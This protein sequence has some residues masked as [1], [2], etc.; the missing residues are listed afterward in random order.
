MAHW[1]RFEG[2]FDERMAAGAC[3]RKEWLASCFD[4]I[5]I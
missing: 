1:K 3:R 4:F 2:S 5:S